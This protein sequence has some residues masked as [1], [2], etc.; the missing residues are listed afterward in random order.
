[1]PDKDPKSATC[2]ECDSEDVRFAPGGAARC[3]KCNTPLQET[4]KADGKME[5]ATPEASV[6]TNRAAHV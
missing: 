4:A 6:Q 2:P 1:M 5:T 3:G